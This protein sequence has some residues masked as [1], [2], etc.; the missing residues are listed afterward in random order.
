M[1]PKK[2]SPRISFSEKRAG[3]DARIFPADPGSRK[4]KPSSIAPAPVYI[5]AFSGLGGKCLK[6]LSGL[7]VLPGGTPSENG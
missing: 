2:K 3:G 4:K 7:F 6:S 5:R 1:F